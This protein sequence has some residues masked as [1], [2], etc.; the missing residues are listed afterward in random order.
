MAQSVVTFQK[1]KDAEIANDLTQKLSEAGIYFETE[2]GENYFDPSFAKNPVKEQVLIKLRPSDFEKANMVLDEYYKS[3]TNEVDKDHYLYDFTDEELKE[4]LIKPD[5]W[6][7]LD[8]QLAQ[9]ILKE[10]G[11]EV[12]TE[13]LESLKEN[14]IYEL[15]RPEKSNHWLV[16]TAYFLL[17]SS[18]FWNVWVRFSGFFIAIIIGSVLSSGKKT[19]P[20]GKTAFMYTPNDRKQGKIIVISAA[21]LV[22]GFFIYFFYRSRE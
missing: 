5:E 14:R 7:P 18:P 3:L 12:R 22:A 20:N 6:G 17:V 10:R 13:E 9:V 19:L 15:S 8:Y 11:R 1:F 4:I 21:V 16:L 2:T